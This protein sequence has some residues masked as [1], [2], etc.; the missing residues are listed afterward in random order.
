MN[1]VLEVGVG[2]VDEEQ[3]G[4]LRIALAYME[5]SVSPLERVRGQRRRGGN[6][7]VLVVGVCSALRQELDDLIVSLRAGKM[8]WRKPLL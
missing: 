6:D 7:L 3:A 5:S 1:R 2:A 8:E 4:N